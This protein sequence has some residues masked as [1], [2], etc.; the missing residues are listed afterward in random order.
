MVIRVMITYNLIGGYQCFRGIKFLYLQGMEAVYSSEALGT[1][2]ETVWFD[3]EDSYLN[4]CPLPPYF[5]LYIGMN[6]Q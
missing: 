6:H 3:K 5:Y 4:E 1:K 2:C